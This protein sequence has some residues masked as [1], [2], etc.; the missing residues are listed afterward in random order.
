MSS[1]RYSVYLSN[2]KL[3]WPAFFKLFRIP[4]RRA[5]HSDSFFPA[6][7][8]YLN[9]FFPARRDLSKF[10]VNSLKITLYSYF[11]LV[12]MLKIANNFNAMHA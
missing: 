8:E 11:Q 6:D 1:L 5:H 3:H 4:R 9:H 10:Y 12:V 2:D 7:Y